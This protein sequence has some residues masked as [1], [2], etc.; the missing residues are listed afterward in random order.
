MVDGLFDVTNAEFGGRASVGLDVGEPCVLEDGINH[1]MFVA[2]LVAGR[3]TGVSA[4]GHAP[5]GLP[6]VVTHV[7]NVL[8]KT[9]TAS[10]V[11]LTRQLGHAS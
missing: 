6:S 3:R 11:E 2:G 10:R 7:S 1:G 8:R 5:A 9:G 4:C